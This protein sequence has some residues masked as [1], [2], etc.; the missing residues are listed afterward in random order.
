MPCA[1]HKDED[2]YQKKSPYP[3][4]NLQHGLG[5]PLQHDQ[6]H[7]GHQLISVLADGSKQHRGALEENDDDFTGQEDTRTVQVL[8]GWGQQRHLLSHGLAQASFRISKAETR[9][10]LIG[11]GQECIMSKHRVS[12]RLDMIWAF[13]ITIKVYVCLFFPQVGP[14]KVNMHKKTACR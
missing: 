9:I 8:L 7:H 13:N 10:Y 3:A 1:I 2:D 4:C 11:W 12:Y 14:Q 6:I 5:H